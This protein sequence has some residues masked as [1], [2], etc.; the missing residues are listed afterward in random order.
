MATL[1]PKP[2]EQNLRRRRLSSMAENQTTIIYIGTIN[3]GIIN[4]APSES[5]PGNQKNWF[6]ATIRAILRIAPII[7]LLWP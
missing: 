6:I 2:P 4:H 1:K 7:L 5:P 3:N